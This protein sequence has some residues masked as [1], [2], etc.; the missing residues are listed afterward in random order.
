MG[1][2]EAIKVGAIPNESAILA[3]IRKFFSSYGPTFVELADGER[4]DLNA[5]LD[6]YGAPLRFIGA[7]FHMIMKDDAAIT[8]EEGMGGEIDRLRHAHF[9]GSA[10]DRCD[11]K[12]LNTQA[13]LIDALG[14][15]RNS[16]GTV[17]ARF[18]V[19]YLMA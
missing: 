14:V 12:I 13:A 1:L 6:F 15:R 17:M 10:L 3:Q 18:G 7:N 11:I 4:S 9:A 16:T 5:L 19:I 8:G 2:A